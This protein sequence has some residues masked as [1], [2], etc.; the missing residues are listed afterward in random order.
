VIRFSFL[1]AVVIANL[2]GIV[3]LAGLASAAAPAPPAG[4]YY[5]KS[6]PLRT[7]AG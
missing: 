3:G 6:M 1:I 4:T 2:G 7:G 5:G